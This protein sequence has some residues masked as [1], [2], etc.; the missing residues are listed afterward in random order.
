MRAAPAL[1]SARRGPQPASV[2]PTLGEY[3]R[4]RR[5]QLQPADVGLV[6]EPGRRVTGL[7]REEVADLA[8]ISREYY[9]RLEQGRHHQVSEQ[10]LASLTRALRL[11]ADAAAYFYR[12]A[13]PAP[14]M[15]LARPVPPVSDLVHRLVEQWSDAPVYVLD[16]NQDLLVANDL[17]H[18]LQ[19]SFAVAGGNCVLAAFLAPPEGRGLEGWRRTAR[20][21]VAALRYHGDPNDPRLQEIVGD[22]S[23]RDA[24][25]RE[26]WASLDARPLTFGEAPAFV[27]G[28]GFG[29]MPWQCLDVPGG[30][31]LLV[32]LDPPGTFASRAIAH[33][34]HTLRAAPAR[35]PEADPAVAA[36]PALAAAATTALARE[37]LIAPDDFAAYLDRA[38]AAGHAALPAAS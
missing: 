24:D 26:M 38:A 37:Q 33:L 17:A 18:A 34:R 25:F 15:S 27:E 12:L 9:I 3:L 6:A 10:V 14:P 31:F 1:P 35:E 30:H 7:R 5:A 19:P 11:D 13:L 32:W 20:A 2:A 21:A 36:A 29:E 8:G 23:V 4:G 16:R 22:L 28:V